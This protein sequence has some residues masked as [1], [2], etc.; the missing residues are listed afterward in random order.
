[1]AD[2][3]HSSSAGGVKV[4]L[5]T[6]SEDEAA[7]AANGLRICFQETSLKDGFARHRLFGLT[8]HRFAM[9]SRFDNTC[10]AKAWRAYSYWRSFAS[11]RRSFPFKFL[12]VD[13]WRREF[14]FHGFERP[15]D[16]VRHRQITKPLFVRWNHEPGGIGRT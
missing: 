16:D 7:F 3:H 15:G 11:A 14:H 8:L 13:G 2:R 12:H 6:R 4:P 10:D 9:N 1:M 5:P